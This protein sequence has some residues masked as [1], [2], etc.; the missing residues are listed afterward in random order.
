METRPSRDTTYW[1][2]PENEHYPLKTWNLCSWT[3]VGQMR[4][5][6]LWHI[7]FTVLTLSY[8]G[9]RKI[10]HGVTDLFLPNSKGLNFSRPLLVFTEEWLCNIRLS[11]AR[12]SSNQSAETVLC[13]R[14]QATR[15][16]LVH[17]HTEASILR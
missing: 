11:H 4:K 17:Q 12:V 9:L 8:W 7:T 2:D 16:A 5:I 10:Q 3:L 6:F 14:F 1:Y 13:N 15:F